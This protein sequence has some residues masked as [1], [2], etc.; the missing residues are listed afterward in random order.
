MKVVGLIPAF[1]EEATI[2]EVINGAKQF[3]D[4][5]IVVD[6]GST[7]NTSTL[8]NEAGAIVVLHPRNLGVGAAFSTGVKKALSLGADILVTF[9]ADG[10]FD[11]SDIP[12]LTRPII[13]GKADF[14]TGTRFF[15][16]QPVP[17]MSSI[18][19]IGNNIF[20]KIVNWLCGTEFSDTQ[21]GFRAY[22]KEAL[23]KL[24]NF[25]RF[26]YTQEVFIELVNKNMR[27]VEVPVRVKA[28]EHGKSKVVKNP[29]NYGL[30]ALKIII[31]AERDYH[32][33]R[34]FSLLS[35]LFHIPGLILMGVA[36]VNWML[37]GM[38]SPY[39]SLIFMG[40]ILIIVGIIFI[41]LALIA[42][43][44]G[45]QRILQEEILYM[46]RKQWYSKNNE[47]EES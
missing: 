40:G 47:G 23:L 22:S 5:I 46:L 6:D 27:I 21:C 2:V 26:T 11:P 13:E 20:T 36:G 25:G 41:I 12:R 28:R 35:L 39:T 19:R 44:N 3:I 17:Y 31:Q 15:N 32:P 45:R 24:T 4:E 30:R 14:V 43:M 18:K 37:T 34:F 1:N 10:Q 16:N 7:D 33:L 29:F 38:T 8:A 9:D 42:D